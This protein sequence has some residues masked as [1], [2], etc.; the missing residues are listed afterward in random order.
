VIAGSADEIVPP[1]STQALFAA[2]PDPKKL[3]IQSGYG[4]GNWSRA[5]SEKWWDE[6]L[7]FIAPASKS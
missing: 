2:L 7:D 5:P 3:I 4:H 6:S 1:W